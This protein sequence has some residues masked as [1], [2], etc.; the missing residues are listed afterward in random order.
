MSRR[1]TAISSATWA[2]QATACRDGARSFLL[3]VAKK[4]V[5]SIARGENA[6]RTVSY[7]NV[8]R[9][10]DRIGVWNGA[11]MHFDVPAGE[12]MP[13]GDGYVVLLQSGRSDRPGAILAAVKSDGL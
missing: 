1:S 6:G 10:L 4:R 12:I 3:Q 11:A 9:S 13:R 5:V 8:V 2:R 7:T